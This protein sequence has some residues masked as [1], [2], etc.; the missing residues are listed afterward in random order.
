[1]SWTL[2]YFDYLVS[3]SG[4][5]HIGRVR[6]QNEDAWVA[7][8]AYGLFAVA[9]GVGGKAAGEVAARM[10][11]KLVSAPLATHGA[12]ETLNAYLREPT[13]T[14]RASVFALLKECLSHANREI[15]TRQK[16]NREER[17]MSCTLDVALLLGSHA[18]I[19]HCG[20]SRVY[21]ARSAT[22]MQLTTDHTLHDGLLA[23]GVATPS[24]PPRGA[25]RLTNGI[26]MRDEVK[27][28]EVFADLT[29]GDRLL[30]CTDGV[31]GEVGSEKD[32]GELTRK[33]L[34][35]NAVIELINA[36]LNQGG[37]D[38][39]TAVLIEVGKQRVQRSTVD[40]GQ[41][42]RDLMQAAHSPILLGIEPELVSLALQSAI[43]VKFAAGATLPRNDASDRVAYVLLDGSVSTPKGWTLGPSAIIYPES[44]GDGGGAKTLCKADVA[45]R[46]LRIRGDDFREVCQTKVE[47][48]AKLYERLAKH[49]ARMFGTA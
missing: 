42:V 39:A 33:G 32:M 14:R 23:H 44:L 3:Y 40:H 31:C 11:V 37:R 20:D 48:A 38:N 7:E 13:M 15:R 30:L 5:S 26:G 21:L 27:C 4:I 29:T 35:E 36:A 1:M 43:E 46:A 18:F 25:S 34:P 22:M 6:E 17:G 24:E 45:T 47:L 28:D 10:A 19:L 12:Q 41:A 16:Q 8:P 9:D 49:L 2:P